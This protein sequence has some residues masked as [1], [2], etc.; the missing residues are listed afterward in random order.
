MFRLVYPCTNIGGNPQAWRERCFPH[1]LHPLEKP[2]QRNRQKE[3]IMT[4][5]FVR[6]LLVCTAI[7]SLAAAQ[8]ATKVAI[9]TAT[10]EQDA[11]LSSAVRKIES[12][13][14]TTRT[15]VIAK[16]GKP[17]K[18][19]TQIIDNVH[20]PDQKDKIH[21]L[22][23]ESV[24]IATYEAMIPDDTREMLSAI[25]FHKN[26]PNFGWSPIGLAKREIEKRYGKPTRQDAGSWHYQ[27]GQAESEFDVAVVTFE[28][29][30]DVVSKVVISEPF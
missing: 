18:T 12:M 24:T 13:L 10:K 19:A 2:L 23:Y 28:F 29:N 14:G 26:V 9:Q 30:K 22:E 16:M 20:N 7:G 11:D 21:Y 25:Q 3:N 17:K 6:M 27:P 8:A 5:G 15:S 4:T 1:R